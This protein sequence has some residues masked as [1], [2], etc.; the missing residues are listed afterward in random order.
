MVEWEERGKRRRYPGSLTVEASLAV[1]LFLYAVYT[2]W[3]FF[4]IL[5]LQLH[6]QSA[7]DQI[8][9]QLAQQSYLVAAW[10][11]GT[12]DGKDRSQLEGMS[13]GIS[14][15]GILKDAAWKTYAASELKKKVGEDFLNQTYVISGAGGLSVMKSTW[16]LYGDLDLRIDYKIAFP[17][18]LGFRAKIP[19]T[20]HSLHRSW[21]GC[22]SNAS[23]GGE[24]GGAEA[25]VYVTE[26][27]TVFH[28]DINCYHLNL[29]I[30]EVSASSVGGERNQNGGKYYPCERCAMAVAPVGRVFIAKSGDRY[31]TTRECSGLKRTVRSV[32]ESQ[33]GL[34]PCSNCGG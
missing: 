16:D 17:I 33:A 4:S 9:G 2:F 14:L 21:T 12:E 19:L 29:K 6:I 15:S 3:I 26:T 13:D 24:E 25:L 23:G 18:L 31:H 11:H 10:Q 22:Q 27:G 8:A 28:R 7:A 32:P 20:Q 30:R 1:P 34:R 5:T